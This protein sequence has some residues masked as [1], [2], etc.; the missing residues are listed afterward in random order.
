LDGRALEETGTMLEDAKLC[1]YGIGFYFTC[2]AQMG[3]RRTLGYADRSY[4]E[5]S[6]DEKEEVD[7]LIEQIIAR[8]KADTERLVQPIVPPAGAS[9]HKLPSFD[10]KS[11][12]GRMM[13]IV[14]TSA[15]MTKDE[16][17]QPIVNFFEDIYHGQ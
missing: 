15:E 8:N 16:M 10:A 3:A 13:F 2:D 6:E 5:L 11:S 7:N 9:I 12:E 1:D 17:A 4:S 14:D